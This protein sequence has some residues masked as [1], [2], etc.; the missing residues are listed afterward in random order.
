MS[1]DNFFLWPRLADLRRGYSQP[2][3]WVV[4]LYKTRNTSRIFTKLAL[5]IDSLYVAA[6][7]RSSDK[8]LGWDG[9]S[10]V[11]PWPSLLDIEV[12][13]KSWLFEY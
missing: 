2:T 12:T 11:M 8:G 10:E 13:P 6:R 4:D 1:L 7:S 9:M 3:K 5:D